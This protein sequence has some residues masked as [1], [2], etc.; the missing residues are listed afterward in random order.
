MIQVVHANG[1]YVYLVDAYIRRYHDSVKYYLVAKKFWGSLSSWLQMALVFLLC[2][3]AGDVAHWFTPALTMRSGFW[4]IS[5]VALG[6]I[7]VGGYRYTLPVL[8]ASLLSGQGNI[9]EWKYS[10]PAIV[11][12]AVQLLF[13]CTG[14]KF[15]TERL[16]IWPC[17]FCKVWQ[18][19]LFGLTVLV[20]SAL[21]EMLK[22]MAVHALVGSAESSV[23]EHYL[24]LVTRSFLGSLLFAPMF[25]CFGGHIAYGEKAGVRIAPVIVILVVVVMITYHFVASREL[26]AEQTSFTAQS[27]GVV[28]ASRRAVGHFGNVLATGMLMV[29]ITDPGQEEERFIAWADTVVARESRA[30]SLLLAKK[31]VDN[32]G[33][34][35]YVVRSQVAKRPTY[36]GPFR[37]S[38]GSDLAESV[39]VGEALERAEHSSQA[40]LTRAFRDNRVGTAARLLV[41]K[42]VNHVG[43]EGML[44]IAVA[45]ADGFLG[46]LVG[47][48]IDTVGVKVEGVE[49]VAKNGISRNVDVFSHGFSPENYFQSSRPVVLG[50]RVFIYYFSRGYSG[51]HA[52]L[53]CWL[54]LISV[55]YVLGVTEILLLVIY[56]RQA[57]VEDEV[58]KGT[59][60]LRETV[61]YLNLVLSSVDDGL[62]RTDADGVIRYSNS[63]AAQ[64]L[65][66]QS[67]R[68]MAGKHIHDLL[69]GRTCPDAAECLLAR[70]L[71]AKN[72][73]RLS[74]LD[75]PRA[76]FDNQVVHR[77]DGSTVTVDVM[78]APLVLNGEVVGLVL[79]IRDV[80]QRARL[81]KAKDEFLATVSHE[82][83]TPLVGINGAL[84]MLASPLCEKDVGKL[85]KMG[86]Q[87]V[88]LA[89]RNGERLRSV[90]E[91]MFTMQA[92]AE[93]RIKLN[94]TSF[95]AEELCA[96]AM[97]TVQGVADVAGAVLD[98][99]IV[100]VKVTADYRYSCQVLRNL[101]SNAIKFSPRDAE[102]TVTARDSG[103]GF[104]EFCVIDHGCGV[105]QEK[106]DVVF[107]LFTTGDSSDKREQGGVGL[108]LTVCRDLVRLMGG[109]IWVVSDGKQ[110]SQ[111]FFTLKKAEDQ[112]A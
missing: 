53:P 74:L 1:T 27:A 19:F 89:R 63:V 78:V 101:L 3:V 109:R 108:G 8:C 87:L 67:S 4:P 43:Q 12:E 82:L 112:E 31:E 73:L 47:T 69:H 106:I 90:I 9:G 104:V 98:L 59:S 21:G 58:R 26:N 93:E 68:D 83:R 102:I 111:F 45:D 71:Q 2:L 88:D 56:C 92:I 24:S 37:Y 5:G 36:R 81:D 84:G 50:G 99:D 33:R 49:F 38:I 95:T 44:A 42:C 34:V 64:I 86:R 66:C 30:N 75:W 70:S 14:V 40:F 61:E 76:V 18:F 57:A 48:A 62:V 55:F 23:L 46:P 51:G 60:K 103:D 28:N 7:M 105:P 80:S 29:G 39:L 110:G 32:L 96:Q 6:V 94:Y 25:F 16:R 97:R 41:V 79:T 52:Y 13:F 107:D 77:T 65:G 85:D 20:F 91:S 15:T 100:N 54:Q 11:L 22:L 35:K 72:L 17:E 10:T